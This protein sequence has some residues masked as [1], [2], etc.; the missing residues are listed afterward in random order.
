MKL[1]AVRFAF[2][3]A[4]CLVVACAQ[5]RSLVLCVEYQMAIQ[6]AD[7]K[8]EV[9][10]VEAEPLLAS[11]VPTVNLVYQNIG[12]GPIVIPELKTEDGI[13]F[14]IRGEYDREL[15][16]GQIIKMFEPSFSEVMLRSYSGCSPKMRV[17]YPGE[18]AKLRLSQRFTPPWEPG[19][20]LPSYAFLKTPGRQQIYVKNW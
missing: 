10:I 12:A 20:N 7:L 13:G 2:L 1:V 3:L 8:F 17:L 5:D 19:L 4:N 11:T 14:D 6:R 15:P 9:E 16:S 18:K